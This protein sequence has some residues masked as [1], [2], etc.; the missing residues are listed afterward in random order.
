MA[1]P[2]MP[3][4]QST[5]SRPWMH[6]HTIT[7][8]LF[9]WDH[10]ISLTGSTEHC[11]LSTYHEHTQTVRQHHETQPVVCLGR[12]RHMIHGSADSVGEY[13]GNVLFIPRIP[14][15]PTDV[16]RH[17]CCAANS[18]PRRLIKRCSARALLDESVFSN[19]QLCVAVFKTKTAVFSTLDTVLPYKPIFSHISVT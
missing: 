4:S 11:M 13:L 8:S 10:G 14:L 16:S 15:S 3:Y 19:G 18:L 6:G 1:A 5:G 17:L 9:S 12:Q 7:L 2:C